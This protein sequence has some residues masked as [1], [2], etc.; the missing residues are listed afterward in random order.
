METGLGGKVVVV[1]GATANI[2]RGIALAFAAEGA[3]VVAIGRDRDQGERVAAA[4][5]AKGAATAVFLP[6]DVT[7]RAAVTEIFGEIEARFGVTDVL[8]NNVG[9]N[10]NL[11]L[12]AESDPG[13]WQAEIDLNLTSTLLCTRAALPAM[14]ARGQGGRIVNIGSTAGRVG[15]YMLAVY[16]A[17][18]GAVHAFTRV[19]AK[20][21]GE[22]GITVNCVAPYATMP[23]D[24]VAETSSG[25]RFHPESGFITK[26]IAERPDDVAR[27]PRK[28]VLPRNTARPAEIAAAVVYLASS[29]ASFVTGQI[30]YVEG[31]ALL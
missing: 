27:L 22:H 26:M 8:V 7:D 16:S 4:A 3:L 13:D 15:D 21:V 6:A 24:L 10:Y 12:F 11:G 25:S 5:R 14:I 18:K 30:Q 19:L 20:E 28:T 2:G 1:T 23:E 29:G 31:G 17:T 9:G